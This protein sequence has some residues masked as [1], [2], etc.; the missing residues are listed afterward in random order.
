MGANIKILEVYISDLNC[1]VVEFERKCIRYR[2]IY[3][4]NILLLAKSYINDK[5]DYVEEKMT[6]EIDNSLREHF[7]SFNKN[8]L[9]EQ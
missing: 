4:E 9:L 2:F 6:K 7:R 1:L 5:V 8:I 3:K